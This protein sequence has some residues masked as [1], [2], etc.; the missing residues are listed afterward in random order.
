MQ[1][2]D[3]CRVAVVPQKEQG[4]S[5]AGGKRAVTLAII[6]QSDENMDNM[7]AR[8]KEITDYFATL[9]PEIDF[10]VCR[11]Q[12]ELLDYTIS[13]LK[14]NFTMGFLLIFI[15]AIYFLGDANWRDLG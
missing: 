10:E 4:Q 1:L 7:K 14:D 8:L 11:N 12:T 3:L 2:K 13:N 9:Y 15:V 6:K 5:V